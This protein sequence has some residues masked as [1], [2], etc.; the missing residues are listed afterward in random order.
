MRKALLL[1]ALTMGLTA[2]AGVDL[3]RD[4]KPTADIVASP[5]GHVSVKTAARE[6]QRRLAEISG[7]KLPIV[8]APSAGF[9]G[10]V[11]L[12]D[13]EHTRKL[14]V[15][16]EDI[17]HDGFKIVA[18]GNHVAI[19]GRDID[20]YTKLLGR[21]K[22]TRRK[23]QKEWEKF[24]GRNW[25]RPC[26]HACSDYNKECGFDLQDG[27]GTLYGVYE[28]LEQLGWRWYMPV[29]DI[30][31]V[32]PK[33][34]DVTIKTQ[35]IKR[36]PAFPVRIYT[37]SGRARFR[38]E[39]LWQKSMKLGTSRVIPIFHA[40][41]RLTAWKPEQQPEAYYGKVNGRKVWYSPKLS[42]EELRR[43]FMVFLDRFDKAFPGIEYACIG[44]PDGLTVMDEKDA[45]AGWDKMKE[46]GARGRFSDYAWDFILDIRKRYMKKHPD[47]K[48][49]VF[50]YSSCSRPPT[51]V[52]VIPGNI[53]VAYSQA[54]P[55]WVGPEG[56]NLKY[57]DE[58]LAK[59]KGNDQLY[60]WEHYLYHRHKHNTPPIPVIFTE[61]M[62]RNFASLYGRCV[63][64]L[65]EV[66]WTHRDVRAEKKLVTA[67]VGLAHLTLLLHARM[68][69]NRDV[70]IPAFI[71][72][73]CE[74]F[75]GPAKGE[76]REFYRFAEAVWTRPGPRIIAENHGFITKKDVQRYFDLLARAKAKA[77]DTVYGKRIDYIRA[78]MEPLKKVHDRLKRT[79]PDFR[80]TEVKGR[81]SIDGDLAKPL[82]SKQPYSFAQLKDMFTGRTPHHVRTFASFRWVRREGALVV[83][84]KCLEPNM[85]RL[86][87][88]CRDRDSL[89]LFVD[90]FVEVQVTTN[91]GVS[92]EI[93]VNPNGVVYDKCALL[94]SEDPPMSYTVRDVAV[95][96]LPGAWTV[97]IK[98][99]AKTVSGA[100]PTKSYP[101]GVNVCR[102]RMACN[103]PEFYMLS[104][105]GSSF[106]DKACMGNLYVR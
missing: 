23:R 59:L 105:S 106:K 8:E 25:R 18:S 30:G 68:W 87:A 46:R 98:I 61:V 56:I 69:W 85:N 2:F 31:I 19:V 79:G 64:G 16:V 43:D 74:K 1:V 78:E 62:K 14:G 7:A 90:D 15:S 95:K 20:N 52:D 81:S 48:F 37:D 99:D 17:K 11:Y 70:D 60:I 63:G 40:I 4:G 38:E 24:C 44:Q 36:E 82:W 73:Y 93:A 27:T 96:R 33:M 10:H 80:C 75:F 86:V 92:P 3:V 91:N 51:N 50:A 47:K 77:G 21:I 83:G 55:R 72:E 34:K 28:L 32:C 65:V 9:A 76:M 49:S 53:V 12:G 42:I 97:E 5:G 104:P 102:Q 29:P 45:T 13:S 41:G 89:A 26:F 67:R 6:L 66:A 22:D 54:S 94:T 35:S 57:R 58:W 103:E 39:F 84:V 100:R 101:W 88:S 71:D